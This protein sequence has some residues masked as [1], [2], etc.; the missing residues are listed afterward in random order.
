LGKAQIR[1]GASPR[2][3]GLKEDRQASDVLKRN[4]EEKIMGGGRVF[5]RTDDATMFWGET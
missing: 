5:F 1:G 3:G 2:G 4:F